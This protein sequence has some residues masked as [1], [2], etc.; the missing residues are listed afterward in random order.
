MFRKKDTKLSKMENFAIFRATSD[1]RIAKRSIWEFSKRFSFGTV[2]IKIHAKN[3]SRIILN[4][5]FERL[6]SVQLLENVNFL[7][8]QINFVS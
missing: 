1:R 7:E 4:I 2:E 8:D 5:K 6:K 3:Y